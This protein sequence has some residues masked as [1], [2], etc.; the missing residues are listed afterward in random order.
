MKFKFNFDSSNS[1]NSSAYIDKFVF[2][3]G[4]V[5]YTVNCKEGFK[6]GIIDIN[7]HK[8]AEL[9]PVRKPRKHK[10]RPLKN[11]P[12][13]NIAFDASTGRI[14]SKFY[15]P[16]VHEHFRLLSYGLHA[17]RTNLK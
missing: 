17:S 14:T 9:I 11:I 15:N 6:N 2:I 8:V 5:I 12:E 10:F 3:F 13:F 16:N 7:E 4:G 1:D